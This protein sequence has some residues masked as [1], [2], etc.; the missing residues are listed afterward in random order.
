MNTWYQISLYLLHMKVLLS[1]KQIKNLLNEEMGVNRACIT[2][3]NI[4]LLKLTPLIDE[5]VKTK[6]ELKKKIKITLPEL[7]DAW[8]TNIDEYIEFPISEIRINF[9]SKIDKKETIEDNFTTA[10]GA[11]QIESDNTKNSFITSPPKELPKYVKEQISATLVAKFDF[12]VYITNQFD[13]SEKDELI[14]DLRDT[15]FHETNHML[16]FFQ[17][18]EKG[19]GYVDVSLGLSGNKNYNIPN[20]IFDIWREFQTMVYYSEPH[21]MR[22]MVQEMYSVR[23]RKPFDEFKNHRYYV[24]AKVMQQFNAETMFDVMIE[25][26]ELYNPDYLI[27]ILTNMWKWFMDDYH[28]TLKLLRMTPNKK[29]NNSI[30]VLQLMK[31][32]Q[33]R[34]NN[35]GTNLIKKFN[36]LYAIE[37]Q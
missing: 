22:A 9:I 33:P 31:L 13:E 29:I 25:R 19:Y 30:H 35:A 36:G 10:G 11:E 21:E 6:K 18:N 23:L 3:S 24:A 34:I 32:L 17:K 7:R 27:P 20:D 37:V 15:I 4:I 2:Y 14:Y 12:E 8:T 26:I 1:E 5:F 28:A 16:E